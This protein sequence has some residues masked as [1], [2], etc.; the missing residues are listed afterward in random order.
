MRTESQSYEIWEQG[1]DVLRHIERCARV[2]YRSGD[3]MTGSTAPAFV[4]SLIRN[5][6]HAALEHGTVYLFGDERLADIVRWNR[7]ARAVFIDGRTYITVDYR[8]KMYMDKEHPEL[9]KMY[10]ECVPTVFHEKRLTVAFVLS[11][12]IANEFVR[13]RAFSFIQ[14]STRWVDYSKERFGHEVVFIM[15]EEGS[16]SPLMEESFKRAEKAY[17]ELL[18]EGARLERARDVLP[19]ATKTVLVMTGYRDSWRDFFTLRTARNAHPD[20]RALA[21]AL[22]DDPRMRAFMGEIG[23]KSDA[24]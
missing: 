1:D 3:R 9:R 14:E 17:F 15:P 5:G 7:F 16:W 6:H 18:S 24:R 22:R 19:L 8:N 21:C 11:R 13:H 4:Q 10:D 2:S 23:E 12:A 20:A